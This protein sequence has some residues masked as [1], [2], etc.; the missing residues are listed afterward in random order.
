MQRVKSRS[1][2]RRNSGFFFPGL[3]FIDQKTFKN[4][5]QTISIISHRMKIIDLKNEKIELESHRTIIQ[6]FVD[7]LTE[8]ISIQNTV[9]IS[10]KIL[11]GPIGPYQ[12]PIW[13]HNQRPP[14]PTG[15]IPTLPSIAYAFDHNLEITNQPWFHGILPRKDVEENLLT[16]DGDFLVRVNKFLIIS[17]IN[18]YYIF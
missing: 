12:S 10:V 1:A 11:T 9:D 4:D 13:N 14:I 16:Q 8:Y 7:D 18:Q 5:S 3:N 2:T 17:D 15:P 6:K